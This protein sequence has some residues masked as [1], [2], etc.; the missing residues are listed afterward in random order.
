[1]CILTI[2]LVFG[3]LHAAAIEFSFDNAQGP[4][5]IPSALIKGA[6]EAYDENIKGLDALDK[7]NIAEAMQH[8][9]RSLELVP[10][11]VDAENNIGV[12]YFRKGTTSEAQK[13]WEGL[14]RKEPRYA[15]SYY[16]LGILNFHDNQLKT[17]EGCFEKALAV[18]KQLAEADVMIGRILLQQNERARALPY[19]KAAFKINPASQDIWSYLA[20]GLVQTGDTTEAMKVLKQHQ[21]NA[22]ALK[23]LG[24]IAASRREYG[25]AADLLQ[26]AVARGAPTSLL[27]DVASIQIEGKQYVP[28]LTTLKKLL[29]LPSK[30]PADAYVL[31]GIAAKEGKDINASRFYFEQG[32]KQYPKDPILR[33]NLGQVYF[34][35]KNYAQAEKTWESMAD[36]LQDPSLFYLRSL[37]AVRSGDLNAADTLAR[38]AL[39]I[40]EK[41]EYHDLL[42]SILFRK[43]DKGHAA[44]EFRAALKI[45]PNLRSSQLNLALMTQSSSDLEASVKAAQQQLQSCT[46]DCESVAYQLAALYFCLKD[47]DKSIQAVMSVPEARRDEKIYRHAALCYRQLQEWDKAIDMLEKARARFVMDNQ[48]LYELAES[49]LY[50]GSYAKAIAEFKALLDKWTDNPWRIHYQMGYAAMELGD[51]ARAKSSLDNSLK[52]KPNNLAARGLLAFINNR[53]GNVTAARDLWEKNLKDDPNNASLWINLGLSFEKDG[54]FI[55]ALEDYQKAAGL[56]PDDKTLQINIGNAYTGL[57][58]YLDAMHAYDQALK[59]PKR[60]LAAFDMFIA[61]QKAGNRPKADEMVSILSREFGSG[62]FAQRAQADQALAKG[63][64]ALALKRLENITEKD[65]AD[66]LACSRIYA[67]K[68][69]FTRARE[70][71]DKIPAEPAWQN[72]RTDVSARISLLEGNCGRAIELWNSIND[73]SF[74][75][76]Y[77]LSVAALQCKQYGQVLQIAQAILSRSTGKDRA[78]VCRVAGNAAFG[79]KQWDKAR[80]WYDQLSNVEAND[81]IVQYNLAVAEYNLGDIEKSHA[82]YERSRQLDPTISNKDIEKRF[83][84]KKN[85]DSAAAGVVLDTL[86]AQYNQA[87]D[88]QNAGDTTA[89]EQIYLQIVAKN[90]EHALAWNNLGTLYAARAE[91]E[92]AEHAYLKSIEKRHDI[93]EAYANL[94]NLYI[95]MQNFPQAKRWLIKGQGHNPDSD[96]LKKMEA[97]LNDSL[98]SQKKSR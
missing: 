64:T 58:Q 55:K 7:N 63:D 89:A 26:Q 16:N 56:T 59:S 88:K 48:A 21:D 92:K 20:F 1:M 9:R 5:A 69:N 98:R 65:P 47:Y 27:L 44:N 40:D 15:L 87:V 38:K 11:Y 34:Y 96:I 13:I 31:A 8:F 49:Y 85:P 62:V 76:E 91:L 23:L 78:D 72:N 67:A 2:L 81:P 3:R 70:C 77:N 73:T 52:A 60:E 30:A 17:A 33:Y 6:N 95:A 84:L 45:D 80:E 93:P 61:A 35:Q 32:L 14:T 22:E 75:F 46:E 86:D 57:C 41:A 29:A 82:Y 71:L 50:A 74:A 51:L 54:N 79:L 10:N 53:E 18:N 42:G 36:T 39:R 4:D 90:P 83:A 19:L 66:W 97:L 12:C 28:A 25:Q 24:S 37:N 68:K 94:I 43:G